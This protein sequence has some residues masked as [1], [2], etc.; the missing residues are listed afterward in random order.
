MKEKREDTFYLFTLVNISEDSG[1]NGEYENKLFRTYTQ[2]R[3]FMESCIKIEMS[4]QESENHCSGML[5]AELFRE[6]NPLLDS[7]VMLR[8][9]LAF[10]RSLFA[11]QQMEQEAAQKK[12][13]DVKPVSPDI[14]KWSGCATFTQEEI[15]R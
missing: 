8:K 6:M 13:Y 2:A 7:D 1:L 4:V 10:V 9:M 14:E 5:R 15:D 12:N 3:Q 11:T